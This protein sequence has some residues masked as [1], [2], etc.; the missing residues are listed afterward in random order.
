[1]IPKPNGES[2]LTIFFSIKNDQEIVGRSQFSDTPRWVAFKETKWGRMLGG[3]KSRQSHLSRSFSADEKT[4][5]R[6]SRKMLF[7]NCLGLKAISYI[8]VIWPNMTNSTHPFIYIYLYYVYIYIYILC[9]YI[10]LFIYI[11]I[12]VYIYIWIFHDINHDI[13]PY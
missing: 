3:T 11:Y 13:F 2:M 8:Y 6:K 10:Y 7:F 5:S 4:C 12:Y 9:I 1:M